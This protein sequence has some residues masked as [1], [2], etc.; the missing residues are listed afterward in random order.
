MPYQRLLDPS[1]DIGYGENIENVG[2]YGAASA[3]RPIGAPVGYYNSGFSAGSIVRGLGTAL[4]Y[5]GAIATTIP[6]ILGALRPSAPS[7]QLQ[8]P[9]AGPTA[10]PVLTA[11]PKVGGG[12]GGMLGTAVKDVVSVLD[13]AAL[14]GPG[15]HA[16]MG[17]Y[18]TPGTKGYH[19]VKKGPHAGM[20]VRN[21]HRNVA[22]IHALRRSLS[23]IHG[24]E[25]IC[26][27]VVHFVHP[28]KATGHAV[29][30][31]RRKS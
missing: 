12:I 10:H 4:S 9:A 26:R 15:A 28:R 23:R 6:A 20:W 21:R 24:F 13:P 31:K 29:F 25:K 8:S 22:N 30:K 14:G 1:M 18:A 16:A 27:K 19:M 2:G 5:G 17:R 7:Q 3:G 11:T